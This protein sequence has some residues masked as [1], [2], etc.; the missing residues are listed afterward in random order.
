MDLN[1]SQ[2]DTLKAIINT[3]IAS[4]TL[5]EE[6]A[7]VKKLQKQHTFTKEQVS[8]F[9][10]LSA[11]DINVI[12]K[13]QQEIP[14]MLPP[15]KVKGLSLLLSLLGNKF[16]TFL[17]TGNTT[18]IRNMSRQEREMLFL[19]WQRSN[20]YI[21][22]KILYNTFMGLSL[23]KSYMGS[24]TILRKAMEYQGMDGDIYFKNHPEYHRVERPSL[25]MLTNDEIA[26]YTEFDVIV[27]G[28]GAGAGVV[29]AEVSA[30]GHSVLVIEKGE[31]HD[32]A[33]LE[34]LSENEAFAK[35]FEKGGIVPST[36]GSINMLS[37]SNFG[38][39]TTI[40]Y[41]A[42]IK[43]ANHLNKVCERIG[44]STENI[45][46]NGPNSKLIDG[47]QKL[48][49]PYEICPQNTSGR[50]HHCGQCYLGCKAGIKNSTT[51][52]WLQDAASHGA[53]FVDQTKVI[54]I[55]PQK[56]QVIGVYCH[57]R[58]KFYHR[59]QAKRVV[60]ACG[61][62]HTPCLLQHSGLKNRHIGHHLRVHPSSFCTGFFDQ[63]I[64]QSNGSLLTAV[65]TVAENFDGENYGCKIEC[66]TNSV[67][68]YSGLVS[69]PGAAKHKELM[70]RHRNSATFFAIVRDKDSKA[71]VKYDKNGHV[72]LKFKLSKHDGRA[73]IEGVCKM[74][75]IL[76]ASGATEIYVSLTNKDP[77]I[78]KPDEPISV[79]NP[80]FLKWLQT[81]KK[82]KP[83]VPSSGHQMG[84]CRM[85]TS[86]RTSAVKESG[87]TWEVKNL[88]VADG[89]LF[90][91]AVGVNPMVTIQAF[92]LKVSESV[93]SSLN[94][95]LSTRS[96][97]ANESSVQASNYT[98]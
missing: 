66:F 17:L 71:S 87:E 78:F 96:N 24:D 86:P 56:G 28:S 95:K 8:H 74:A 75:M 5:D 48:G 39:G 1:A 23:T 52:T 46:H 31:Y 63:E 77:F 43:F 76:V 26:K 49:Y 53:K 42:S 3:F 47:C 67:A 19:K 6:A 85:G 73:L 72:D 57:V 11:Q 61:S 44:A 68:A 92:A 70:L 4:L 93:S 64:N 54:K 21:Y 65:S 80:R 34:K 97:L 69:W 50:P 81:I 29:A 89:S 18:L 37:G 7:L 51:N 10:N 33:S 90:P 79:D 62:L 14:D 20:S 82:S 12:Q 60:V 88:Y 98:I 91:T 55:L 41:L 32:Q 35:L 27:I 2:E 94:A 25:D 84:S 22:N 45:I 36:D 59:I 13:I 9:A 38:G 16:A 30:A 58:D 40:N 15:E 83:P